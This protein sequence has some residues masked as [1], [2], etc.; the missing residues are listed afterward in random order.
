MHALN[1]STTLRASGSTSWKTLCWDWSGPHTR[2]YANDFH[3][4]VRES[5]HPTS[6]SLSDSTISLY[7]LCISEM[8]MGRTRQ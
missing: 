1:P 3:L 2:S 5:K 4:L 6:V 8:V 7:P